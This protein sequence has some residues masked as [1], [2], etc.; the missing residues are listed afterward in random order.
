MMTLLHLLRLI[1]ILVPMVRRWVPMVL[2][3]LVAAMVRFLLMVLTTC[4]RMTGRV[5]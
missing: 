4:P 3:V 5:Q 1:R 2:S